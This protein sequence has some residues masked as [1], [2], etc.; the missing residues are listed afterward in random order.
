LHRLVCFTNIDSG[1]SDGRSA[2]GRRAAKHERAVARS[3]CFAEESAAA[4][5]YSE[6]L[7]WLRTLEAIGE[8]LP[9]SYRAKREAWTAAIHQTSLTRRRATELQPSAE[10]SSTTLVTPGDRQ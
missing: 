5:D 2:Q 10:P 7:A 8:T 1:A 3:L 6:A 9:A 4:G